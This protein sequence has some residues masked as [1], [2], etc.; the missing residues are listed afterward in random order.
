MPS[1]GQ[2]PFALD[3]RNFRTEHGIM[4]ACPSFALWFSVFSFGLVVSP[5]A[6]VVTNQQTGFR[7]T[8][9]LRDG[10]RIVGRNGD[11]EF[12][13]RSDVLGDIKL[14]IGRIRAIECLAKTNATQLATING[15]TLTAQFITKAV[16][17]EA[18]FGKLKL[19]VDLIRHVQIAPFGRSGKDQPGLV[20]LWL[21][22]DKGV[23]SVGGHDAAVPPDVT[24]A[25]AKTGQGFNLDGQSHRIIVP[26]A[27]ELNFEAS[28]DF[29]LSAWIMPLPP[30]PPL[31]SD[32]MSIIDKRYAPDSAHCQGYELHLV[33]GRLDLRMS[34]SSADNGIDWGPAGPDL[35]DGQWH[36][37]AA[38]LLRNSPSGGHLYVDGQMV[39]T[40]DPTEEAGDLSNPEPLRIGNHCDPNYFTFF[41]GIIGKIALYNRALSDS[42]IQAMY[43]EEQ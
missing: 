10:S 24:Y 19:P 1:D 21:G 32:I 3:R 28:Q 7:L 12:Q 17:V 2:S 29:S 8:I 13:F 16:R 34:D 22:D 5:A 33:G 18:A 42:E 20:A 15:D 30:P 25:P 37:V 40:F 31:T 14:P 26:H 27:P 43:T 41:H 35:R 11:E 6:S 38:T 39:L 9:D 23:D 4:K 36:Y